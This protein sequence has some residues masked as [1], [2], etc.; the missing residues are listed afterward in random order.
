MATAN[1]RVHTRVSI[2]ANEATG[3]VTERSTR[4]PIMVAS[5]VP[6]PPGIMLIAPM[7]DENEYM[8]TH[9]RMLMSAEMPV[10]I[11]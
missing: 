9:S 7:T 2:T 3:A 8:N 10:R 5:V 4:R 6:M 1:H 11:R